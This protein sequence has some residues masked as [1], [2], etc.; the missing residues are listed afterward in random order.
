MLTLNDRPILTIDL[1]MPKRGTWV[2]DVQVDAAEAFAGSVTL[3]DIEG[4]EFVGTVHRSFEV[5]GRVHA[6]IFGGAGGLKTVLRAAHYQSASVRLVADEIAAGAGETIDTSSDPLA[7][8]LD[9]WSRQAGYA[10]Q[11]LSMVADEVGVQWR[12]LPNGKIW[13]GAESDEDLVLPEVLELDRDGVHNT[14]LY[15]LDALSLRPGRIFN[16]E[17]IARVHYC[18][19]AD[20]ALRVKVWPEAA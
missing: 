19:T 4:N 5:A 14:A 16:G 10:G 8:T 2:L 6:R 3:G 18:Q 17:R 1:V 11:A 9:A 15:G 13:L 7:A 12:V 20:Q